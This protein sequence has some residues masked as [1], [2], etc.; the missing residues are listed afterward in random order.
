MS[1]YTQFSIPDDVIDLRELVKTLLKYKWIIIAVMIVAVGGAFLISKFL[2]PEVYEATSYVIFTEPSLVADLESSIQIEPSVPDAEAITDLVQADSI[3]REVY[4]IK[5][6]EQVLEDGLQFPLFKNKFN[7]K[8]VGSS[9]LR[10]QVSDQDPEC[11]ALIANIWAQVVVD[12]LNRLYGTTQDAYAQLNEQ[13]QTAQQTWDDKQQLLENALAE[14][15]VESLESQYIQEQEK[16]S[17]I[18]QKIMCNELLL[19]DLDMFRE[20][21]DARPEDEALRFEDIISVLSL[22]QRWMGGLDKLQLEVDRESLFGSGYTTVQVQSMIQ[23]MMEIISRDN[24]RLELELSIQEELLPSLKSELEQANYNEELR[25]GER[26][27]AR[28]AYV[29]LSAQLEETRISLAQED[30]TAKVAASA[31]CPEKPVSPRVVMIS[32]LAGLVALVLSIVSVLL[33][34]WWVV[35][36]NPTEHTA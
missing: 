30:Q 3:L 15:E 11:A 18:H 9:Q 16:L 5:D 32:G 13:L 12:H 21:L 17:K 19:A 28:S 27:L 26:D 35:K 36:P 1:E 34:D 22:R 23:E 29:A 31:D 24:L 33:F 10:L 7:A 2:I 8:L 25:R 6:V 4:E 14:S 20:F